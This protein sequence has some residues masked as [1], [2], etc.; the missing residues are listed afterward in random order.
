[1]KQKRRKRRRHAGP[2]RSTM[3]R[4]TRRQCSTVGAVGAVRHVLQDGVLPLSDG[5][6][7]HVGWKSQT[8]Q[9]ASHREVRAEATVLQEGG[10]K[11]LQNHTA[12]FPPAQFVPT[13]GARDSSQ[14]SKQ[15]ANQQAYLYFF[16]RPCKEK[17]KPCHF[18][19]KSATLLFNLDF[20]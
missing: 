18:K 17:E 3:V 5:S 10:R 12:A 1:M 9:A 19:K 2:G 14:A 15:A 4:P 6:C 11:H 7:R 16:L 20:L 8:R 13:A